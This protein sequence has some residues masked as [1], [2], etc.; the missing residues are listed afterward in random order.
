M[1][2][3]VER[4]AP[5]CCSKKKCILGK[6]STG[7]RTEVLISLKCPRGFKARGSWHTHPNG[8]SKL[9]TA[10][11]VNLR[12]AKLEIGCVTGWQGTKCYKV[13]K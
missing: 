5:I 9:S 6:E 12:K 4:G 10:D 13:R 8:H 2:E 1:M 11:I 3:V 7:T